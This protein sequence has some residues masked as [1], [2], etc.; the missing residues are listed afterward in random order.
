[1]QKNRTLGRKQR[2]V[3]SATPIHLH[4]RIQTTLRHIAYTRFEVS[5]QLFLLQTADNTF[6]IKSLWQMLL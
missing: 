2:L 1:M 3:T 4:V 6:G 5:G